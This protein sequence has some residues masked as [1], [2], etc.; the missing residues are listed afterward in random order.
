M[1]PFDRTT[2]TGIH[3]ID[4]TSRRLLAKTLEQERPPTSLAQS[5][6]RILLH[7]ST[8][9]AQPSDGRTKTDRTRE[10]ETF[11]NKDT[12]ELL[13]WHE[14][15][16]DL[17]ETSIGMARSMCSVDSSF[18]TRK[19]AKVMSEKPQ[20]RQDFSWK[21]VGQRWRIASTSKRRLDRHTLS[22][23]GER[24]HHETGNSYH[25]LG[26]PFPDARRVCFAFHCSFCWHR[27]R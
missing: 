9:G 19:C 10:E 11:H 8:D 15:T 7:T 17:E 18:K 13:N 6:M 5:K 3:L 4:S 22:C 1:E 25:T 26:I 16:W 23:Q 2:K 20:Q 24:Q 21:V 12:K 27:R 14:C